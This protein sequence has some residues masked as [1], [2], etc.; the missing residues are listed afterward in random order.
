MGEK[1]KMRSEKIYD[2]TDEELVRLRSKTHRL[3]QKY[4]NLFEDDSLRDTIIDELI[5][6]KGRESYL[7]GPVYFDYGVFT[8]FGENCY[9]LKLPDCGKCGDNGRSEYR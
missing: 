6:N 1:E 8:T 3:S 9:S 4:N 5:P 7:Q 2:S